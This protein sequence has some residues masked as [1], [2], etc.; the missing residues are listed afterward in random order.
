MIDGGEANGEK[1]KVSTMD[2]SKLWSLSSGGEAS[3]NRLW[4]E[5]W[6]LSA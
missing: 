5:K 2:T 4:Q 6:E 3:G 1:K